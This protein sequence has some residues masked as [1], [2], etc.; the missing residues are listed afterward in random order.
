MSTKVEVEQTSSIE[1]ARNKMHGTAASSA[2]S[3]STAKVSLFAAKSGF[4]IPKNKLS[5]SL[6]PIFQRN[7]KL[8]GSDAAKE[9]SPKQV[10]RKTKWG[11]DLTQDTT[12]KR[13]RALAL[14]VRLEQ[15]T[16][17]LTSGLLGFG[18]NLD[19][20]ATLEQLEGK[21]SS[22]AL[23]REKSKQLELEKREL[24]GEILRLNA[25]FK[26]PPDYKPLLKED[27]IPIPVKEFPGYNFIGLI[28]GPG[29]DNRKKLEKETGA[30][31]QVY[32]I[33]AGK[34]KGETIS[35]DGSDFQ[36][37]YE[38]IY[39]HVCADTYDKVDSAVSIIELLVTSMKGNLAAASATAAD[40]KNILNETHT[41]DPVDSVPSAPQG[42]VDPFMG[43]PQ[44]SPQGQFQFPGPQPQV[45]SVPSHSTILTPPNSSTHLNTLHQQPSMPLNPT[46]LPLPY[47]SQPGET[48]SNLHP[49]NQTPFMQN[50]YV[51][52]H[53]PSDIRVPP[54][55]PAF[56][57][58]QPSPSPFPS[59][60][61]RPILTQGPRPMFSH[62]NIASSGSISSTPMANINPPP[63][64]FSSGPPPPNSLGG[65]LNRPNPPTFFPSSTPPAS[66]PLSLNNNPHGMA[67]PRGNPLNSSLGSGSSQ[68]PSRL[69]FP[70][71]ESGLR[72]NFLPMRS[73]SAAGPQNP[74]FGDFTFQPRHQ[75]QMPRFLPPDV[76][77][78]A[79]QFRS[80]VPDF[81]PRPEFFPRPPIQ[82]RFPFP[83]M[84]RSMGEMNSGPSTRLPYLGQSTFP[85]GPGSAME[86]RRSLRPPMNQPD[87]H[88]PPSQQFNRNLPF[89]RPRP[90]TREQQIYDPFSPTSAANMPQRHGDNSSNTKRRDN[91]PEYEDL[92]ASVGVK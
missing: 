24:I 8:A 81:Q 31:I 43:I 48:G 80:Q 68:V 22:H 25:N 15:I 63:L 20:S 50:P 47:G 16:Q 45:V 4:V 42:T 41:S 34:D 56:Q 64:G 12:V 84:G 49:P 19:S 57:S 79:P 14:Q 90:G 2:T 46:N 1:A 60:V 89:I 74:N 21:S 26:V 13:G 77:P 70:P 28:F 18:D 91:D 30:K 59:S 51:N 83:N 55:N 71:F 23:D 5:G 69:P 6:V 54:V 73:S 38:E 72:S 52:H 35:S 86:P 9:E 32:G 67:I 87:M 88:F 82:G 53:R 66:Q 61:A 92:M 7:K 10:Q 65:P 29:G 62:P 58:L 40:D 3:T 75:L 76:G 78:Q 17:Q 27:R 33:K 36:G 37:S 44:P 39:V 11:P 85:L